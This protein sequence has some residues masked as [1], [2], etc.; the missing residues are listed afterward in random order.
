MMSSLSLKTYTIF[1]YEEA[2]SKPV[3][4]CAPEYIFF[5]H[6]TREIPRVK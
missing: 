6:N 2:K 4:E 1:K 5:E 3:F